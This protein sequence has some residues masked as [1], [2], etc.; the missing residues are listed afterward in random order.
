M[1][2][3][4]S[5]STPTIVP[6]VVAVDLTLRPSPPVPVTSTGE[7][8]AIVSATADGT[9]VMSVTI[10]IRQTEA[11]ISPLTVVCDLLSSRLIVVVPPG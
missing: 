2:L 11:A 1:P 9:P 10:S 6:V 7:P 8:T 4:P 3:A 5:F